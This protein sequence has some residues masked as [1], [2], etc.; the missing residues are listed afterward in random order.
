MP[1][2]S[3]VPAASSSVARTGP[4]LWMTASLRGTVRSA[5]GTV[6]RLSA[7]LDSIVL[8]LPLTDE[9]TAT[10][11][12]ELTEGERDSALISV[13]TIDGEPLYLAER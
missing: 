1:R 13:E 9:A 6:G 12:L 5:A 8:A 2:R 11:A 3:A 4:L 10:V 7:G